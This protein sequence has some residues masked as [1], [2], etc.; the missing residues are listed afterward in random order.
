[1]SKPHIASAILKSTDEQED[2]EQQQQPSP[3]SSSFPPEEQN[4]NRLNNYLKTIAID[5]YPPVIQQ[6]VRDIRYISETQREAQKD[7]LV[8]EKHHWRSSH[9]PCFF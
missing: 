1:M 6:A 4:I 7:D 2:E 9:S 3:S 8:G 5:R